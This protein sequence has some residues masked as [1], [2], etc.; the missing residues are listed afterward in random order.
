MAKLLEMK[1]ICKSFS[2][3]QILFDVNFDL[4]AGQVHALVGEN[5]AGKSTL[6]KTLAGVHRP[7]SGSILID[8]RE[9]ALKT[10]KDAFDSSIMATAILEQ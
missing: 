2:G 4:E 6:I 9:V 8:G 5:G 1:D 10:P 7:D 3:T